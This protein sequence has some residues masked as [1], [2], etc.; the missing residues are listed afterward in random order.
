M[1]AVTHRARVLRRKTWDLD[2]RKSLVYQVFIGQSDTMSYG[3]RFAVNC[4][5]G[6]PSLQ[7]V[8][9]SSDKKWDFE[10]PNLRTDA[11]NL[12][13]YP[14]KWWIR[15]LVYAFPFLGEYI[16][17]ILKNRTLSFVLE[18]FFP[19]MDQQLNGCCI[20]SNIEIWVWKLVHDFMFMIWWFKLY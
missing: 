1:S 11:K 19:F 3:P 2:G 12:A 20:R 9:F 7:K 18:P 6:C 4:T 13:K 5:I 15:H 17:Q 8:P 14:P 10:R 16:K